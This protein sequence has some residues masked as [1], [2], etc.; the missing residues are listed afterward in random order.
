MPIKI[1]LPFEDFF[2]FVD[3][4]SFSE[5]HNYLNWKDFN[6]KENLE[7]IEEGITVLDLLKKVFQ[8][9]FRINTEISIPNTLIFKKIVKSRINDK[10]F[11]LQIFFPTNN[12]SRTMVKL[13]GSNKIKRKT[14]ESVKE[15]IFSILKK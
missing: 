10:W 5:E 13:M 14:Q 3:F 1:T 15:W 11:A 6:Q 2:T 7:M 4:R 9:K 8:K 12:E